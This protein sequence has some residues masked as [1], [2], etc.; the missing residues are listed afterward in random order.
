MDEEIRLPMKGSFDRPGNGISLNSGDGLQPPSTTCVVVL[1]MHGGGTSLVASILD[2]LGVNMH[3]NP[4]A[5]IKDYLNYEDSEFVR[6]DA[7]ILHLAGG[8]WREPPLPEKVMGVADVVAGDILELVAAR[9]DSPLWGWKDPRAAIT[10]PLYHPYLPD[11]HYIHVTRN[12]DKV[13]HSIM[14]RGGPPVGPQPAGLR[15]ERS[16]ERSGQGRAKHPPGF[17]KALAQEHY[18]RI[19]RFLRDTNS[20]R[21]QLAY[22]FLTHGRHARGLV[23]SIAGFLGLPGGRVSDALSRIRPRQ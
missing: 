22:E 16:A 12:L 5:R 15:R 19:E 20:P 8:N 7:R 3:Y 2:A 17:W 18:D 9:S 23:E 11:P 6:L 14:S 10:I 4:R 1:G 13:V 21:L